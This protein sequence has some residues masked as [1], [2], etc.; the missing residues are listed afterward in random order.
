MT[1]TAIV[2]GAGINGLCVA[3][4]LLQNGWRVTVADRGR[5][6]NPLSASYDHHR[7]MRLHYPDEPAYA[8]RA[9]VAMAAWE[10]LW[11]RIGVNRY[12][13]TGMLALCSHAFDWTDRCRIMF[14]R[15]GISYRQLT[16]T[17][18]KQRHSFIR[19]DNISYGLL[20][21]HGGLLMAASMLDDL[22]RSLRSRGAILVENF[23]VETVVTSSARARA[24]DGSV[25]E[26]DILVVAAG[27]GTSALLEE[28][29]PERFT[30]MRTVVLYLDPPPTWNTAL[31]NMP[32]WVSL[33]GDD[34]L[35]GAP[36]VAGIP[37][38]F[39]CGHKTRPGN[40]ETE[41]LVT[42]GE[43]LEILEIY[44]EHFA[45][46]QEARV[47]ERIANFWTRTSEGRFSLRRLDRCYVLSACSGHGFKFAVLTGREAAEAIAAGDARDASAKLEVVGGLVQ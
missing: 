47:V 38:K 39:G 41:R 26:G 32:S 42:D 43:T 45:G 6:P 3:D 37:M 9:E 21:E 18:L 44:Q 17:E 25:L 23:D 46:L 5:L 24:K 33:G 28:R 40:P 30:A 31:H 34:A 16:P 12:R 36:P 27:V 2:I 1:P 19:A 4:A 8:R 22:L 14:E 15:F 35:W 11:D 10:A 13:Q 20:T 29:L 7:F